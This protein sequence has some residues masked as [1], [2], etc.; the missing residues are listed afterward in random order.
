[1][2]E[3]QSSISSLK[4]VIATGNQ[5]L[6][7]LEKA[8][9]DLETPPQ[10]KWEHGDVFLYFKL[11]MICIRDI[12]ASTRPIRVFCVGGKGCDYRHA[13]EDFLRDGKFLFN[14]RCFIT[15]HPLPCRITFEVPF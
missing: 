1:M 11:P 5:L 10:H 4:E 8:Q 9:K 14:N 12:A 13:S 7:Q 3:L 2:T 15:S 6:S